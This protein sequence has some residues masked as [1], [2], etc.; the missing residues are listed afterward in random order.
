VKT[1]FAILKKSIDLVVEQVGDRLR[2]DLEGLS[3]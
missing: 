2:L 1:A 3:L